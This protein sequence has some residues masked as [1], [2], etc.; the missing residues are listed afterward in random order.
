MSYGVGGEQLPKQ[1]ASHEVF[2]SMRVDA[3]F[4]ISAVQYWCQHVDVMA[5]ALYVRGVGA[6]VFALP[7]WHS[8][9][10]CTFG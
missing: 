10:R 6:V 2:P 8:I 7:E 5:V 9:Q 3:R 4:G 1:G